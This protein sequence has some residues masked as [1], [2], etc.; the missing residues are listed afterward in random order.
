MAIRYKAYF[1]PAHFVRLDH[2]PIV[3]E[4]FMAGG[5]RAYFERGFYKVSGA[6]ITN[7][8]LP[9]KDGDIAVQVCGAEQVLT[10]DPKKTPTWIFETVNAVPPE[11]A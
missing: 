4:V 11:A 7:G 5:D 8:S 2:L 1:A 10:Y 6:V 9:D 3:G